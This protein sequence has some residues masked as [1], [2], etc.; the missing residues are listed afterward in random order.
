MN[1]IIHENSEDISLYF[2]RLSRPQETGLHSMYPIFT[3]P[4]DNRLA[5]GYEINEP[6]LVHHDLQGVDAVELTDAIGLNGGQSIA[7]NNKIQSTIVNQN[8]AEPLSGYVLGRFP[9]SGIMNQV[10]SVKSESFMID[11]GWFPLSDI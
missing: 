11:D 9:S 3:H 4:E 5:F 6:I 1:Y 8:G 7:F 10:G 2:Y